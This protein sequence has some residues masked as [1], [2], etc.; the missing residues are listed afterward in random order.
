M[1]PTLPTY[2]H[3]NIQ[4]IS[5]ILPSRA[6]HLRVPEVDHRGRIAVPGAKQVRPDSD[7]YGKQRARANTTIG[8]SF[9]LGV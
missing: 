6:S 9:V 5:L 2:I 4:S 1:F 7:L 3:S 8:R